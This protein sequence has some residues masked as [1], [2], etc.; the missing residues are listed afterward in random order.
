M[1]QEEWKELF[2]PLQHNKAQTKKSK[3]RAAGNLEEAFRFAQTEFGITQSGGEILPALEYIQGIK[4][5]VVGEVGTD[6]AEM[7]F[8][9]AGI[10]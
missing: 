5:T 3:L 8:S 10:Q 4:P 1:L 7:C 2:F 9:F 6:K